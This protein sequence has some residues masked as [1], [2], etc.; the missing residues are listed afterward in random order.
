MKRKT[1][2][3]KKLKEWVND[4]LAN[5]VDS[6]YVNPQWRFGLCSLLERVLMDTGNYQGYWG[7]RQNEVPVGQKPGIIFDE[8]P[9]RNHVYPD[10]SRRRYY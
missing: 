10:D 7:L 8:S 4:K 1:I 6:K 5:S 2:E 9:A 3:I